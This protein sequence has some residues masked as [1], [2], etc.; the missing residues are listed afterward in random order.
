M[1]KRKFAALTV[2]SMIAIGI[3]LDAVQVPAVLLQLR[4]LRSQQNPRQQF[5]SW[6][7]WTTLKMSALQMQNMSPRWVT[8]S[9]QW[10][11]I[12]WK[13]QIRI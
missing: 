8:T 4:A 7:Y 2:A 5:R 13:Q 10:L 1:K 11:T 6:K 12:I 9:I 3:W